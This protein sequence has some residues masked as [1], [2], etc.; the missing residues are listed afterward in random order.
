MRKCY[1]CGS[2]KTNTHTVRQRHKGK[3]YEYPNMPMWYPNGD[4][5]NN[6]LCHSCYNKYFNHPKSNPKR[7]WFK[8]KRLTVQKNP[9]TGLCSWC[10]G[11]LGIDCKQTHIH[12]IQ[13]HDDD[14]M[15]A[16]IELC[17]SCHAKESAR[18]RKQ[19]EV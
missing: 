16:T 3:T 7:F 1:S 6:V 13:Y 12:H 9:R 8:S 2:D 15:K 18:E 19:K 10:F 11:V 14:P 5:E 4:G 17:P